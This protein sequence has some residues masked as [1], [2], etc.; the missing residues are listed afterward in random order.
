MSGFTI[1]VNKWYHGLL[2]AL[3]L[4][5]LIGSFWLWL[6]TRYMHVEMGTQLKQISDGRHIQLQ[7]DI[8][9]LQLMDF[10]RRIDGGHALTTQE[11][12][13]FDML[14]FRLQLLEEEKKNS[15]NYGG[16]PQ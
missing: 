13:D 9:K 6:D 4:L 2:G 14:K 10:N 16:L 12:Q 11:Q 1:N 15:Q 5:A 8:I 7:M 3:P